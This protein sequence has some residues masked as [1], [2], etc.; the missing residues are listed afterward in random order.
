MRLSLSDIGWQA[1]PEV[2]V[3]VAG[4]VGLAWYTSRVLQPKALVAGYDPIT[5]RQKSWFLAAVVGLWAVSD[6]PVHDVAEEYLYFVHMFQHLFISMLVPAM[7]LLSTP[8]WLFELLVPANSRTFRFLAKAS[9]PLVAGILFNAVTM[10]LHWSGIVQWSFESGELHFGFHILI[11]ASGLLM[12][13]PVIGPVEAWRIQPLAQCF[14]LFMMS[15]VP[16]VPGGWLVF[17]EEAVYRHYDTA[18]RLWGVG[19][20][21]DQQAAGAIM[22]LVGGFFLWAV[23]VTI[24]TRFATKELAEDEAA[25]RARA[26]ATAIDLTSDPAPG[27]TAD[28]AE[29][30][31]VAPDLAGD[32]TFEQVAEEFS[33]TDAPTDSRP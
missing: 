5:I 22:K 33:R 6:W 27:Q 2:W 20:L 14:Y 32:L 23:I 18:D 24:F 28:L 4:I 26:R 10:L 16:T 3:L 15:L 21:T 12:W 9:R 13:M 7:F 25:R 30:G 11:F 19:V 29:D 31:Q 8:R 17:A 1:H